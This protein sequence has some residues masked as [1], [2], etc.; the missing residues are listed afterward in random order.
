MPNRTQ[1]LP[2]HCTTFLCFP[3]AGSEGGVRGPFN[4]LRGKGCYVP[5]IAGPLEMACTLFDVPKP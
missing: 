1:C 2:V 5:S 4:I 3:G